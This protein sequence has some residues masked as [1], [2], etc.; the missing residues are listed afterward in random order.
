MPLV[1]RW[2]HMPEFT[3]TTMPIR[4][5]LPLIPTGTHFEDI[6]V[7]CQAVWAWMA[8]LLQYWQDHMTQHLYGGCFS[9]TSDLAATLI[10]D[11]NPWLPHKSRFGWGYEAMHAMLWL[12]LQDQ[13][14]EEHIAEWEAQ[15]CQT[16]ALNNLE[17]DTEVIHRAL[18]L[19]RQE[20]K[21]ITDSKEA[22][23]KELPPE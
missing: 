6:H 9:Q 7:R 22:A 2:F 11:I 5:E 23:A 21:A 4:G 15:K 20:D 3:Q 19:K 14:V 16:G 12:Y 17:Q 10:Q 8:V 1:P 13:F 18:I